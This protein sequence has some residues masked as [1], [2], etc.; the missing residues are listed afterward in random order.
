MS[1]DQS[2]SSTHTLA[3]MGGTFDPIH[4]AHLIIAEEVRTTLALSQIVFVPAGHPPHKAERGSTP[5]AHRMAMVELAIAS[6]PHFSISRIEVD[7]PG[8]SYLVETL[9]LLHQQW[10][11]HTRISF[12]I[13]W[14][15]LEDFPHWYDPSGILSQLDQLIVVRRPGYTT[16]LDYLQRLEAR[17][18]GLHERLLIVE[19]PQL[20]ISSTNL[21]QRVASGRTIKYQ[22][23]EAVERYIIE[24]GLYR[25]PS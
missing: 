7:R 20:D 24:N 14:D 13:G 19:I 3:L 2:Q 10:E 15:S 16:D 21:R 17:L 1:T 18:P 22:T 12:I 25:P 4:H 5:I 11:P 23:P 6:N 8:P 9:R